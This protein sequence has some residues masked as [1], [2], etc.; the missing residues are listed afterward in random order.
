ML[1]VLTIVHVLAA[2]AIIALV[3]LQH[4]RGA[5][6]GAAFGGGGGGAGSVFGARGPA[7]FLT[8]ATAVL[9]TLFFLT[10]LSLGYMSGDRIERRS[11]TER[12][13]QP[14]SDTPSVPA[15]S[16]EAPSVPDV[17]SINAGESSDS[18][19]AGRSN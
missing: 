11:V 8:R 5:D 12:V 3:L 19:P 6:A 17:P 9:A 15:E 2:I 4:G 18:A 13:E 16:S 7:S 10:S 1:S 14:V